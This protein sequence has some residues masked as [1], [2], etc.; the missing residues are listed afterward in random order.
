MRRARRSVARSASAP[1]A[2]ASS[3]AAPSP[4][5]PATL[6]SQLS[7]RRASARISN[8]SSLRPRR[9]VHVDERRVE[10]G[11]PGPAHVEESGTARRAQ[12]LATRRRQE[13]A[14]ERVDVDGELPDRLAGVEQVRHARLARCRADRGGRVHEPTLGRD[15]RDRDQPHAWRRGEAGRAARRPRARR[16]S[17]SGITSTFDA[18]ALRDLQE[19]RA[20]CWRTRRAT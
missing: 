7:K 19:A 8:V 5:R 6:C 1:S 10:L 2:R 20:R 4:S 11:D 14:A 3:T 16:A 13:V 18:G 15:P 9:G 17:S 12:V